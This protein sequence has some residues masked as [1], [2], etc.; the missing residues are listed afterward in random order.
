MV[1]VMERTYGKKYDSKLSSKDVAKLVRDEIKTLKKAGEMPAG[2]KTSVRYESF[3]GGSSIRI[4]IKDTPFN[5]YNP[6]WVAY[7][8]E[9]PHSSYTPHIPRFSDEARKLKAS[10]EAMLNAYNHDGSDAMVDYFDVK[11]YSSVDF[12]WDL[13]KKHHAERVVAYTVSKVA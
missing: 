11:F 4:S 12:D 3:A 5:V 9:N 8:I 2:V 6:E 1:S 10:L 7:D 13:E